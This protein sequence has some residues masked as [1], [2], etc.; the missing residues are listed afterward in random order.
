MVRDRARA[1]PK[2]KER[3][4]MLLSSFPSLRALGKLLID[5]A[6]LEH[7]GRHCS[8]SHCR[9]LGASVVSALVPAPGRKLLAPVARREQ[10]ND[11]DH[12]HIPQAHLSVKRAVHEPK[13]IQFEIGL[14]EGRSNSVSDRRNLDLITPRVN[15]LGVP[16]R[17]PERPRDQ[18]AGWSIVWKTTVPAQH[19]SYGHLTL[20]YE[21]RSFGFD[22]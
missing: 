21:A 12:G 10:C 14:L 18:G 16:C 4:K 19:C 6:D 3:T 2:G 1:K 7:D 5:A 11:V 20:P 9:G 15:R 22:E 13:A 17:H 8:R